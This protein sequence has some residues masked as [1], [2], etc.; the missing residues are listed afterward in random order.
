MHQNSQHLSYIFTQK[1][2]QKIS[3]SPHNINN[4]NKNTAYLPDLS[5]S[6]MESMPESQTDLRGTS[7]VMAGCGQNATSDFTD[8]YDSPPNILSI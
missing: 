4:C 2:E 3:N 5:K 8:E 7:A 1:S 6:R